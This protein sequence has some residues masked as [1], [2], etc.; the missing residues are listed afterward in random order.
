[1]RIRAVCLLFAGLV[2]LPS[3]LRAQAK[4]NLLEQAIAL[5]KLTQKVIADTEPA[6]ACV[7]VSRRDD[8]R[9]LGYPVEPEES[10]RLG[11]FNPDPPRSKDSKESKR[12]LARLDLASAEHVPEAFGSGVVIDPS[13]L[14][15][16]NYH[17][18]Q[19]AKKVY[20]RLP[21]QKGSYADIHAADSRS[22]LAVLR[23]LNP[24][25]ALKAI[26]LG[27]GDKL[28]RGQFLL[29]LSN[30]FAAG[31][32]DGQPSASWGIL[33]NIRRRQPMELKEE[34][35]I[36]PLHHYGVLLQTDSRLH[37]GCS[38]GALLN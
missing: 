17:V 18:V 4:D 27:D 16:T 23:L 9:Q 2:A 11:S 30:P 24:A 5:Q 37:L 7:I 19:G 21:G 31:F 25:G 12:L 26:A 32:R 35:R 33:S 22:D 8:Y 3:S 20:V 34:E 29:S 14:I 28:E 13:G 15:L 6:I 10:G 36:Q 1:M 38:G